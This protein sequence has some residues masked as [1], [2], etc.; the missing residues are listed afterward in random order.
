M[1]YLKLLPFVGLLLILNSAYLAA[2]AEPSLFY[3]TNVLFHLGLGIVVTFLLI[4]FLMRNRGSFGSFGSLSFAF[5]FVGIVLGLI[6]LFTGAHRPYRSVLQAHIVT[7]T[8]G[9][10]LL[11]IHLFSRSKKVDASPRMKT[12]FQNLC[13]DSCPCFNS[14]ADMASV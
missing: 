4:I 11:G 14:H 8:I 1:K 6:L 7:T 13:C 2:F 3:M 12:L 5:L 10:I 9:S